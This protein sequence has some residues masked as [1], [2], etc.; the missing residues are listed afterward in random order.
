ME[1]TFILWQDIRKY[2][3]FWGMSKNIEKIQEKVSFTLEDSLVFFS[4]V[5]LFL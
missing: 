3:K 4:F 1:K 5:H 2:W